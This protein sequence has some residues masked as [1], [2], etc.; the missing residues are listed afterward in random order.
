MYRET[1]MRIDPGG[2]VARSRWPLVRAE[3]AHAAQGLL[4]VADRVSR[5]MAPVLR[6]LCDQLPDPKWGVAMGD[7]PDAVRS[8]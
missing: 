3:P 5:K 7:C 6:R 8:F 2:S 1:L 4:I